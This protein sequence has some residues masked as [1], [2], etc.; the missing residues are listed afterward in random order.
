[1]PPLLPKYYVDSPSL[2]LPLP[3]FLTLSLSPSPPLFLIFYWI[4]VLLRSKRTN[5]LAIPCLA[6]PRLVTTRVIV[7]QNRLLM[8]SLHLR[9]LRRHVAGFCGVRGGWEHQPEVHPRQLQPGAA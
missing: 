4:T 5:P 7:L 8:F 6:T 1:M 9:S 2:Y 3:S